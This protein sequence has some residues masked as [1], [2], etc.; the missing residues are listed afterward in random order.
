MRQNKIAFEF[1]ILL[2]LIDYLGLSLV[3]C[4]ANAYDIV[5][6]YWWSGCRG[7]RDNGMKSIIVRTN[8]VYAH[9]KS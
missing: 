5:K 6:F 8:S 1:T 4:I 9:V 7:Q 2:A 3:D